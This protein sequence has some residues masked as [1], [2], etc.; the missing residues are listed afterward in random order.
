M[1]IAMTT[2][3]IVFA[4]VA[5]FLVIARRVFRLALKLAIV[6]VLV[7]LLVAGAAYGWWRGWLGSSSRTERP[8]SNQRTNSNRR[9]SR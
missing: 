7:F 3:L 8:Q 1:L 6:C 2:G 5:L 4:V 9:P